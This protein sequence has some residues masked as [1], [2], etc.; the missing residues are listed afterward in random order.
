M[1][2]P[3]INSD[4]EGD[5]EKDRQIMME[6]IRSQRKSA[7]YRKFEKKCE[8]SQFM[9]RNVVV[10]ELKPKSFEYNVVNG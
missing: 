8:K 3:M 10:E 6:L 7:F 2:S 5:E 4:E 9:S 1:I